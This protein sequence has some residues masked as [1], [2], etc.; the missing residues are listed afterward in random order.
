Q[1]VLPP[2]GATVPTRPA[3]DPGR[4]GLPIVPRQHVPAARQ[5]H[6][7]CAVSS[8]ADRPLQPPAGPWCGP[9]RTRGEMAEADGNRTRLTEVLG[10]YG[11]EDRAH[12]QM[13][14][15]SMRT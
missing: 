10:H 9:A 7:R 15:A 1:L 12:H 6:G 11:F 2:P 14:N 4:A 5:A 8:A 3:R 13:R